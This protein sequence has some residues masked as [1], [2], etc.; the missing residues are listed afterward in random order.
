MKKDSKD[1]ETIVH[2][3]KYSDHKLGVLFEIRISTYC[4]V[5]WDFVREEPQTRTIK[6]EVPHLSDDS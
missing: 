2:C 6:G 1:F 4:F 3:P 5:D